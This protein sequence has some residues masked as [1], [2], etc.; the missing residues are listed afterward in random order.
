MR[1]GHWAASCTFLAEV[2]HKEF[3]TKVAQC[4]RNY[5]SLNQSQ[6]GMFK[7]ASMREL[8]DDVSALIPPDHLVNPP[9]DGGLN[10]HVVT[11][12]CRVFFVL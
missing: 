3:A 11:F 6:T 1:G 9:D 2:A 7:W 8:Y 12:L 10:R 4:D 5:G